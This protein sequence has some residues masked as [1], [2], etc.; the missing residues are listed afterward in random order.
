MARAFEGVQG[1]ED[2]PCGRGGDGMRPDRLQ[3]LCLL[4]ICW[5]LASFMSRCD[6][7]TFPWANSEYES[8]DQRMMK[9]DIGGREGGD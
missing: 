8:K 5:R 3:L 1:Q 4:A 6:D 7:V 2:V 9:D